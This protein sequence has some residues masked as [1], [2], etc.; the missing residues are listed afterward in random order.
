[1][2]RKVMSLFLLDGKGNFDQGFIVSLKIYSGDLPSLGA[3]EDGGGGELPPAPDLPGLYEAWKIAYRNYL[4]IRARNP[5]DNNGPPA[6]A[7]GERPVPI[8]VAGDYQ[9]WETQKQQAYHT[10]T[11]AEKALLK[12]FHEWLNPKDSDEVKEPKDEVKEPKVKDKLKVVKDT[13]KA[14][15]FQSRDK[16][17]RILIESNDKDFQKMP[18]QKWDLLTPFSLSEVGLS[19][20]N[21][22]KR[23]VPI[24]PKEQ[25]RVLVILGHDANIQ[26]EIQQLA[27]AN[28][29][30]KVVTTLAELDEPLWNEAWDIIVFNGHSDTSEKGTEGKFQ[31]SQ[32]QWLKIEDIRNHLDKAIY[33]GL[34]LVI[35]NSCDGL[36]LAHQLGEGQQLYLPQIMVMRDLLPVPL[37]P[38]FLQYFFEEFIKGISLYSALR[39]TR[40]RLEFPTIKDEYPCAS[41]LPVICQNPAVE[42]ITWNQLIGID[43]SSRRKAKANLQNQ[44]SM[45]EF[46]TRR[47]LLAQVRAEVWGLL[48]QSLHHAVLINLHKENQPDLVKRS[49]DVEVKVGK[50]QS[51]ES[52]NSNIIQIFD[53]EGIA[54]KLLILGLPGAGKTTTQLELAQELIKRAENDA[55]EPMPVL[56]N[57][58]SWKDDNQ[59]IAQW[60]IQELKDKYRFRKKIGENWLKEHEILP[61][62]DGLDE[63]GSHRQKKC[64]EAINQFIESEESPLYIV[65][66]SRS[67]EYELWET[68]LSL[69]GAICLSPLTQSQIQQYLARVELS[70]L[71]EKIK[72]YSV[73]LDLIKTPLFL[74]MMTLAYES[75][76]IDEWGSY[77]T[78]E[79]CRE[80]LVKVYV[81]RML[82]RKIKNLWYSVSKQP[83]EKNIKFWLFWLSSKL[84]KDNQTEFMIENMQ[85]RVFLP[86]KYTNII[87]WCEWT[88]SQI[89]MVTII[90]YL[91]YL[92]WQFIYHSISAILKSMFFI[93]PI[94]WAGRKELLPGGKFSGHN[95]EIRLVRGL[96][97]PKKENIYA[98]AQKYINDAEDWNKLI[99][100][101]YRKQMIDSL[102]NIR[103]WKHL[104]NFLFIFCWLPFVALFIIYKVMQNVSG[105]TEIITRLIIFTFLFYILIFIV[106]LIE[107]SMVKIIDNFHDDFHNSRLLTINYLIAGF[108]SAIKKSDTDTVTSPN[109]GIFQSLFTSVI[110]TF[111]TGLTTAIICTLI[112]GIKWGI[113]LGIVF[114]IFIGLRWGGRACIQHFVMRFI[115]W[116]GGYIPWNYARFLNY[117]TERMLLQR[118]GGRYRFIHR[119]LQEYFANIKLP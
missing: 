8:N 45:Q 111:F 1:M 30:I 101:A 63:L 79:T 114:G 76:S 70:K 88:M 66:C 10:C 71:W 108:L 47:A 104:S 87:T 60:L 61:I 59:T 15:L 31:L 13:L 62:L 26:Q 98:F 96:K 100:D 91:I 83:N 103:F 56:F 24:K 16:A 109:E 41:W 94:F 99:S 90:G 117:A 93:I 23:D 35:F 110:I 49:W 64:V 37:A 84:E 32:G 2:T 77:T 80:Y 22:K 9:E 78:K 97:F 44:L 40:N 68:P 102:N 7:L 86:V 5:N 81:E 4:D 65:V 75:L 19:S 29:E 118:V 112:W 106:K 53:R 105:L 28:I 27:T 14:Y 34:K 43:E 11:Q 95:S 48:E 36:G 12:R 38:I 82:K 33:Q 73:I 39:A 17:N 55:N 20:P 18:W 113:L 72:D 92:Y 50:T 6:L 67:E 119:F 115:L 89:L 25:A 57:L 69:N 51:R 116:F 3:M 52:V 58:S 46:R 74:S 42:P 54:G 107:K 85:P 21:F